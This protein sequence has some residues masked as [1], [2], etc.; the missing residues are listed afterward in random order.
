MSGETLQVYFLGTAG[1]LPTPTRNPPCIMIRRGSDTI[2]F[3]CGEGAQQQMMRARCGFTI[4]AIFVSHWHA[5]H[6][7]GIFGLV[8]TMSFNGRTEPLTIYGP[9][10]VHEFVRTL[11]HVARFN[12][13]FPMESVELTQGSWVR[14]DGYTVTAFAAKHGLPALGFILEED[15]RPGRFNREQAIALGVPPGPLFGRLQRGETVTV[16]TEGGGCEV[17]PEQVMGSS[18]HGR[19]IV[20]TGDTRIIHH[21]IMDIANDADL[22]IH[23]ATYDESEAARAAEFYH[24][25]AGQAGEAAA[26]LNARTL[27]LVHT[28]SRYTDAQAH[29]S[30]AQKKFSG[31]ILVPNDLE[32]IEVAFRD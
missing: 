26:A 15:P 5:D 31:Q 8:Q 6:F 3:D 32:M 18:R 22:L 30:D 21:A 14:F 2:L 12:L 4:N 27:V 16:K 7:L 24:A 20:Y 29:V 19:K 10:W 28:S 25:T 17:R 13:K 1:A 11:R 23:D 9:E